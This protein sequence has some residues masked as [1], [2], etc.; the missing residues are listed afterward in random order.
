MLIFYS[1]LLLL[2]YFVVILLL[3]YSYF[4]GLPLTFVL[5]CASPPTTSLLLLFRG[6]FS[7]IWWLFVFGVR[8]SQFDVTIMFP[9]LR[10]GEVYWHNMN[11]LPHALY[12]MCHCTEYKLTA[13]Q[14]RISEENTVNAT[15][16]LFIIAKI[17]NCAIKQGGKT[18]YS[19]NQRNLQLQ[20]TTAV[21][22]RRIRADE[23]RRC[24]AGLAG[25]HPCLQDRILLNYTRIENVHKVRKKSS[26]F[27]LCI[28][29][30]QTFSFS[31]SPKRLHQM[32][33]CFC[34]N[35]CY[36]WAGATVLSCYRNW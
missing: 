5:H 3:Y 33:E 26:I 27:W 9:N 7:D 30:Q 11:I 13:L 24:T 28:K 10:F 34:V 29:V 23:R 31:F 12:F 32:P 19:L 6:L 21:M 17:S 14:V 20:N 35:N 1:L 36:F 16:Q 18:H 2:Q 8:C 4:R 22:S 15:T 25:A